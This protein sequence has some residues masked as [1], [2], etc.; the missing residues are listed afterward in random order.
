MDELIDENPRGVPMDTPTGIG[1]VLPSIDQDDEV[2]VDDSSLSIQRRE[3]QI[4]KDLM[5]VLL[6]QT[7]DLHKDFDNFRVSFEQK[8]EKFHEDFQNTLASK[9]TLQDKRTGER[10]TSNVLEDSRECDSQNHGDNHAEKKRSWKDERRA[11]HDHQKDLKLRFPKGDNILTPTSDYERWKEL[12]ISEIGNQDCTFL[13]DPKVRAP[14]EYDA[15]DI[16]KMRHAVRTYIL[17]NLD[18]HHYKSVKKFHSPLEM[19]AALDKVRLP[20]SKYEEY[21]VREEFNRIQYDPANEDVMTFL[22]RFDEL[23]DRIRRHAELRDDDVKHNLISAI[24]KSFK[25]IKTAEMQTPRPGLSIDDVKSMMYEIENQLK[26]EQRRERAENEH[27]LFGLGK[28]AREPHPKLNG[29]PK[30][31]RV[32]C[33]TCGQLGH[34]K[35]ECKHK[36]RMCYNCRKFE[37]HISANCPYVTSAS[38]PTLKNPVLHQS[39]EHNYS[40]P[41]KG[42]PATREYPK[43]KFNQSSGTGKNQRQKTRPGSFT[44][45]IRLTDAFKA[46]AQRQREG[47]A[48]LAIL[49]DADTQN[50]PED[51]R[52]CWIE[53]EIE[54]EHG[55]HFANPRCDDSSGEGDHVRARG[56]AFNTFDDSDTKIETSPMNSSYVGNSTQSNQFDSS[57][58]PYRQLIRS[59]IYVSNSTRMDVAFAINFLSRKQ[60]N[61]SKDDWKALLRIVRYLRGTIDH[62]ILMRGSSDSIECYVDASHGTNDM[63]G[64]STAGFVITLYGDPIMWRSKRQRHVA[65]SS[66]E[67]E[68][69]AMSSACRELAYIRTMCRT[70]LK[71]SLIPIVYEDNAPAI[72]LAETEDSNTFKHFVKIAF[73]YVREE[74]E[75]GNISIEWIPSEQQ[76]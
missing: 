14:T 62:G 22:N 41:S 16:E 73:H 7:A 48:Q 63:M 11:F 12:L 56:S 37:G 2:I 67:A 40:G 13:V 54:S 3:N 8:I 29:G 53:E 42:K 64:H 74:L 33:A 57:T 31:P 25:Q 51:E 68:Y 26:D 17:F 72:R 39:A 6:A 32:L 75:N 9:V 30:R 47:R 46:S 60:S 59:L 45:R 24:S 18:E 76:L 38:S 34:S 10:D 23:V 44:W 15:N 19:I 52:M 65:L 71:S 27:A 4:R 1:S 49:V 50:L 35:F 36:R 61:F 70:L 20:L 5:T 55:A 21:E 28:R 69:V 58:V 43:R 66:T